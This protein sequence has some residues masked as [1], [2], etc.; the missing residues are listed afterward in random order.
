ME[1]VNE[2]KNAGFYE[3]DFDGRSLA[4]GSLFVQITS[5]KFC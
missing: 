2:N 5:W 3:I 4:S 1:L